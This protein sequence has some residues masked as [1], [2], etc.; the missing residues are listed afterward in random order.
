MLGVVQTS[1]GAGISSTQLAGTPSTV[2]VAQAIELD[3]SDLSHTLILK[4]RLEGGAHLLSMVSIDD[5]SLDT[6]GTYLNQMK[7]ILSQ[8]NT[9]DFVSAEYT[10]KM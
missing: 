10:E 3:G 8:A 9:L 2:G 7:T 4:D 5:G 6:V 1:P